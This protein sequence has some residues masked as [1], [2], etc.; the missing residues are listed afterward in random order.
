VQLLRPAALAGCLLPALVALW[1][2]LSMLGGPP[3]TDGGTY[4]YNAWLAQH[5][6]GALP[7]APLNVYSWLAS[8]LGQPVDAPFVRARM[9][10][11]FALAA[12][13]AAC[14]WLLRRCRATWPVAAAL[15]SLWAALLSTPVFADCG[16]KNPIAAASGPMFAALALLLGRAPRPL[17][18]GALVAAACL[19]REAFAPMAALLPL[20]AFARHG[21]R[22]AA[23]VVLGGAIVGVGAL[24]WLLLRGVSIA[25]ALAYFGAMSKNANGILAATGTDPAALRVDNLWRTLTYCWWLLWWPLLAALTARPTRELRRSTRGP[26]LAALAL[27]LYPLPEVFGKFCT[28]YHWLQLAPALLVLAA[29]ADRRLRVRERARRRPRGLRIASWLAFAVVLIGGAGPLQREL[30]AGFGWHDTFGA[31]MC[32]GDW[33]A[34]ATR[35]NRYLQVARWLRENSAADDTLLVSGYGYA[36]YP[37]AA[38]RPANVLVSDLTFARMTG[39]HELHPEW[40]D[41]LRR[42]PP[43]LVFETLRWPEPMQDVWPDF[44]Q[45][46]ELAHEWPED[47]GVHYG[48]FGARVWRRR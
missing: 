5:A 12:A 14:A 41:A 20:M 18:A 42:D 17:L 45:R 35:H 8:W 6:S 22:A 26:L 37:L 36:L 39:Q 19:L 33:R 3:F 38:R 47:P 4:H 1:L 9:L 16:F 10:D 43:D 31:I 11:A 21:G 13:A 48:N 46:Y 7:T 15:A 27:L 34:D 29:I 28:P 44:A 24:L 40:F 23:R 30:A 25:D 32:G 2:R